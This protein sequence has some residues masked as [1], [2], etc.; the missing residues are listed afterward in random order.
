MYK[1]GV[2]STAAAT[3]TMRGVGSITA[4]AAGAAVGELGL[5]G[6]S[7]PVRCL[8]VVRCL[9]PGVARRIIM[10]LMIM[11]FLDEW[12]CKAVTSRH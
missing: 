5:L 3:G 12:G 11:Q 6:G 8:F 9:G 2:G 10:L 1:R 7:P 4:V